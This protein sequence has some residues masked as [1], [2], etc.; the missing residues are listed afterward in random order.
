MTQHKWVKK[1]KK[2]KSFEVIPAKKH[3]D[4]RDFVLDDG[5]YV[6]IKIYRKTGN[7][8]VG[9]CDYE[10]SI[11]KE[12]RGKRVQDIYHTIFAYSNHH[13]KNWFKRLDHAAYLGK[14]LKKAE[15]AL[16]TG[17]DYVQE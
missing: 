12:F 6:L 5:C 4:Y 9:I 1:Q 3:D 15:I 11:L 2:V 10:H 17:K 14:E 16:L 13:K 7:I 8:G